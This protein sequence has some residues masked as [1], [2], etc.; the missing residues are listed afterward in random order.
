MLHRGR[1][2][3][4]IFDFLE[5]ILRVLKKKTNEVGIW[6]NVEYIVEMTACYVKM[7]VSKYQLQFFY[8][9]AFVVNS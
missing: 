2:C 7:L 4:R 3:N 5:T 1:N 8:L 9:Y 6:H